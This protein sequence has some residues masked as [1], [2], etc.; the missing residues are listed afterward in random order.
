[1]TSLWAFRGRRLIA[2]TS[3]LTIAALQQGTVDGGWRLF[4]FFAMFGTGS[5]RV[6]SLSLNLPFLPLL[7]LVGVEPSRLTVEAVVLL[8][9]TR[10]ICL[11]RVVADHVLPV[12]AG[13]AL[14]RKAVVVAHTA[15]ADNL[16]IVLFDTIVDKWLCLSSRS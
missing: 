9:F 14:H 13:F 5:S 4:L 16:S 10:T 15:D 6:E 2:G 3:T 1:M 12:V 7:R 8:V 11:G